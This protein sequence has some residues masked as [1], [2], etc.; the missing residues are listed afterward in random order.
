[1]GEAVLP[2]GGRGLKHSVSILSE[3][4]WG[5]KHS[6]WAVGRGKLPHLA[7]QM[8]SSQLCP[9]ESLYWS[10]TAMVSVFSMMASGKCRN[11]NS[12]FC[13]SCGHGGWTQGVSTPILI[14]K[15]YCVLKCNFFL[16]LNPVV[17][18]CLCSSTWGGWSSRPPCSSKQVSV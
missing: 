2:E 14:P 4:G 17:V 1:M 6:V 7:V 13:F 15:I 3:G 8:C 10:S 16:T 18:T 12:L 9:P 5:L 11:N